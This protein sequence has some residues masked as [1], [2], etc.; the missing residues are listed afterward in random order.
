MSVPI[1]EKV[2]IPTVPEMLDMTG[3]CQRTDESA[4]YFE[5]MMDWTIVEETRDR[6]KEYSEIMFQ[7]FLNG[8]EEAGIDIT[9]PIEMM[10]VLKKM[11][12]TKFEQLFHP[13]VVQDGKD[14]V[15]PML[16][17]ALWSVS[18]N[19]SRGIIDQL[20]DTECAKKL[21]GKRI[22]IVSGDL[23]YFGLYVMSRVLEDLGADVLYGGNSMDAIDVLDL[24]DEHGIKNIGISL[25]NGQ[26]LPY[27]RLLKQLAEE[28]GREYNFY[29]GGALTSFLHEDDEVPVDVTE[30]I[31]EM[32]LH[33]TS[34]VE[35]LAIAL[36]HQE[37]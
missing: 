22:C 33:T 15:E 34:S 8:M 26:A 13:S 23:H 9:N 14:R 27:A 32:G 20:K 7:N 37:D 5:Q 18:E 19:M 12:P 2:A 28:R 31:E 29:L 3:A 21:K 25:H 24:A 11:D 35:E 4:P 1:S 16:P 36:A 10:V 6:I 17:A 30:Y